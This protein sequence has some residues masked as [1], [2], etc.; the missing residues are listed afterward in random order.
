MMG[1]DRLTTRTKYRICKIAGFI[2]IAVALY[3]LSQLSGFMPE[4][5]NRHYFMIVIID[6]VCA[7]PFALGVYYYRSKLKNETN[8][9]EMRTLNAYAEQNKP[10]KT[11]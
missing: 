2:A 3:S 11:S 10:K 5:H 1:I 8:N 9:V 4:A 6:I 7:L